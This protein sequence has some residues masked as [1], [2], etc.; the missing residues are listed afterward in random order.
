MTVGELVDKRKLA[1][2]AQRRWRARAQAEY[3]TAMIEAGKKPRARRK[4]GM[5]AK[6]LR[7]VGISLL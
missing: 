7:A 5:S 1:R 3:L 6:L 2:E 4:R